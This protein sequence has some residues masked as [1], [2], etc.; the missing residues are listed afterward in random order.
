MS[1]EIYIDGKKHQ[2]NFD[3]TVSLTPEGKKAAED[4]GRTY[5]ENIKLV[6]PRGAM[7]RH[8]ETG[9]DML[10]GSGKFGQSKE[11]ALVSGEGGRVKSA[12]KSQRLDY[13]ESGISGELLKSVSAIINTKLNEIVNGL[14]DQE[15]KEFLKPENKE[16]RA[17]YREIAQLEGFKKAL[18]DEATVEIAA[19]NEAKELMHVMELFR[20]GVRNGE[21]AA[22]PIVG[23]GLFAESLFKRALK[24]K[25]LNTGEE[26]VGFKDVNEIGGLTK[27][28]T[29]FRII[30]KRDLNKGRA[31]KDLEHLEDDTEFEYQFTD[32][33]RA[34]LFEGKE[35]SLDWDKVRELTRRAEERFS[36]K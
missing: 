5:P 35:L 10:R 27:Q 22:I 19:E 24:V 14:S 3:D 1:G 9:E 12:R 8:W 6:H 36:K 26:K 31:S 23:S 25:D 15:K 7:S 13:K 20:R 28:A 32:L 2:Y 4:F 21:T 16:L 29:A 34:K 17:K 33:E 11:P 18:E 30:A